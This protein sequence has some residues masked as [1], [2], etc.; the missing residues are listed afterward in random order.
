MANIKRP[1]VIIAAI[2]LL[3]AYL[4][5]KGL[6]FISAGA[7]FLL[8]PVF[9]F[10]GIRLHAVALL[11]AFRAGELSGR[12]RV[13]RPKRLFERGFEYLVTFGANIVHALEIVAGYDNSPRDRHRYPDQKQPPEPVRSPK[14][15]RRDF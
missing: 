6:S 8:L 11:A 13:R 7:A 3:S 12:G 5:G 4:M 9:L 15:D 10:L 14:D 2:F 1:A